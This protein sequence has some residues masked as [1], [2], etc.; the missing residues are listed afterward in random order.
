MNLP[1]AI[2]RTLKAIKYKYSKQI[3]ENTRNKHSDY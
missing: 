2:E 1:K 3:A